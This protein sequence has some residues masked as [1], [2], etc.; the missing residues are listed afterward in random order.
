M[1]TLKNIKKSFNKNPVLHGIDVTVNKGDIVV[2]VGPSGSGKTTLLRC[3]NYLEKPDEGS[4][5]IDDFSIDEKSASKKNILTL[6]QK[7]SNGFSAL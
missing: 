6:R 2:I 7:N 5:S 3:M 1:I 4:I